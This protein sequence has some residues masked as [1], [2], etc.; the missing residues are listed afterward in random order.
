VLREKA[1]D[2]ASEDFLRPEKDL[3]LQREN[4]VTES[5]SET[6]E[7]YDFS[8]DNLVVFIGDKEDSPSLGIVLTE[9]ELL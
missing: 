9:E 4:M 8:A 3:E 6:S 5:T 2:K 1:E 7:S